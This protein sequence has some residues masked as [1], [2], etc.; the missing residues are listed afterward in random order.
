MPFLSEGAKMI[1]L[2]HG[3]DAY[4]KDERLKTIK[5]CVENDFNIQTFNQEFDVQK[6][7]SEVK[8]QPFLGA[9][10]LVLLKNISKTKDKKKVKELIE[11]L[12]IVP[13]FTDIVFLEDEILD[14]KSPLFQAAAKNGKVEIF[15]SLKS[16]ELAKWVSEKTKSLGGDIS[17]KSAE[18]LAGM[19]GPDLVRVE[20][21]LKKLITFDPK[22]TDDSIDQLIHAD[23][24]D[25][26]FVLMDA[27]SEKNGKQ[28]IK[29]L[30][31]FLEEEGSEIYLL[32]MV[33][34]QV[35]NLLLVKDLTR[36]NNE[37]TI[38]AKTK[39]HPYVVKK[40]TM[41]AK[42]FT[43]EELLSIHRQLVQI[44]EEIKSSSTSPKLLLDRL[45]LEF[46]NQKSVR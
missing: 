16:Y 3:E 40:C 46:V 15:A 24:I 5:A 10:K 34:R 20:N 37:T 42:N 9:K 38:A 4:R 35:R 28:A 13:E 30:H 25:S 44:D 39:L 1:I 29:V 26:I 14:P 11:A 19:M 32:T 41:Q 17:S 2:L 31:Q 33:A 43:I 21:E 22:I 7:V 45:V 18:K 6:V 36:D 12:S 27:I 8:T 23:S